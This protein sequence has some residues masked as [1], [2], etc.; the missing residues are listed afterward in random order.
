MR[1]LRRR[2]LSLLDVAEHGSLGTAQP[3][4]MAIGWTMIEGTMMNRIYLSGPMTGIKDHNIPAFNAVAADM[5]RT[6]HVVVNPAEIVP[7]TGT[8]WEDYMRADLQAL[9]TCDTIA[10]MT[11][12]ENS[13]GA[14]LELHLAHRV[15]MTVVFVDDLLFNNAIKINRRESFE[16]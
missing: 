14:H 8:T 7:E 5:R 6:G 11:G 9:L 10:L 1:V 3:L 4:P 15:G 16:R 13:K 12:W 2:R